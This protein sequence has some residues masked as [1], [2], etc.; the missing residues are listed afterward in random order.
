MIWAF[1]IVGVG[2]LLVALVFGELVARSPVSG[3]VYPW[4]RR[5]WGRRWAWMTGWVYLF[6]LLSTIASVAY[7]AA[8]YVAS[9]FGMESTTNGA[10]VCALALILISTAIN[11]LG[12][13]VVAWAAFIGF[14]AELAGAVSSTP[15]GRAAA[16][17]T[18]PPSP[19]PL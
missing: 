15:S 5:L 16:A 17:A 14:A 4:A 1:A 8:P 19:P 10:I 6:A 3:G 9:V 12:T 2:Q 7:G 13:K 11:F 18:S